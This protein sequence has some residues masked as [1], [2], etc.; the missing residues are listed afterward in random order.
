MTKTMYI[1]RGLPGSG[2]STLARKL[3]SDW[4]ICSTDKHFINEE[5]VYVFEPS[6]LGANHK[7]NQADVLYYATCSE[8][9]IVV[10]NTNTRHW[11]YAPYIEIAKDHGY[12]IHIITV[13]NPR[14]PEH[15][16]ACAERN[17]HGV[18]LEAIVKMSE[19]FES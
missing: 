3:A 9:V 14:D 18:S 16:K 1:L 15:V 5:G 19:R 4:A 17:T 13:G 7:K 10:D 11:E 12:E 6:R 8:P 2:K